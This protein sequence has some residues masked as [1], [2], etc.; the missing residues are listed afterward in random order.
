MK[1]QRNTS[2]KRNAKPIYIVYEEIEMKSYH[3]H[4]FAKS[5]WKKFISKT[6]DLI[7]FI[8]NL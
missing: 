6:A 3:P 5:D 1:Q 2:V 4:L 7:N 8:G